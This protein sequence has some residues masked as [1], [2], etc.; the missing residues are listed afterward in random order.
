M[1]EPVSE[2]RPHPPSHRHPP[3]QT[4]HAAD[5]LAGGSETALWKR[6]RIRDADGA[7]AAPE[8]RLEHVRLTSVRARDCVRLIRRKLERAAFP[9]VEQRAER[10][11]RI[12]V[13]QAQPVDRAVEADERESAPVADCRI[14]ANREVTVAARRPLRLDAHPAVPLA[15]P[16]DGNGCARHGRNGGG[17]SINPSTV[18]TDWPQ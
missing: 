2:T 15:A 1:G 8:R 18:S 13:R 14:V 17:P 12:E 11:R 7:P 10:A 5:K 6:E 3:S 9:R 4:L 16:D